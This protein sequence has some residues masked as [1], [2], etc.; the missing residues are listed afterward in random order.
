MDDTTP[1]DPAQLDR[2]GTPLRA[3]PTE[4]GNADAVRSMRSPGTT[5]PSPAIDMGNFE[6]SPLRWTFDALLAEYSA[7]RAELQTIFEQMDRLYSYLLALVA[8]VLA[9]QVLATPLKD[10]DVTPAAYLAAGI[11]ALWFP[12]RYSSLS[13]GVTII[14]SYIRDVIQPKIANLVSEATSQYAEMQDVN[15]EKLKGW[16]SNVAPIIP[17]AVRGRLAEPMSWE[18]F[19]PLLRFSTVRSRLT[20]P[21]FF[22]ETALLYAPS[23]IFLAIYLN[24]VQDVNLLQMGLLGMMLV[25][26]AICLIAQF[27]LAGLGAYGLRLGPFRHRD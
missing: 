9:S 10:V 4:L 3:E 19:N 12:A 21:V 22:V 26:L 2:P 1:P 5:S 11:V 6:G 18:T 8:A 14:G 15:P 7:L 17:T 27:S 20:I 25:G 23:G 24:Q 13:S 16:S